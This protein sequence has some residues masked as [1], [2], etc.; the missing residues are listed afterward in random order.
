MVAIGGPWQI[1]PCAKPGSPGFTASLSPFEKGAGRAVL[2]RFSTAGQTRV[3][4]EI[5]MRVEGRFARGRDYALRVAIRQDA[6]AL[7]VVDK[8][9]N[10]D[11]VE[12]LFA[13][14]RIENR[15]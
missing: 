1:R 7:L 8:I 5:F 3:G 11:L 9:G 12:D 6:P 10:H 2:E 15:A 14:R 13:H 4:H